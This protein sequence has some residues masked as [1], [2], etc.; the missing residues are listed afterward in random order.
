MPRPTYVERATA[1]VSNILGKA[2]TTKQ[3]KKAVDS[4]W[5]VN[6]LGQ[7][8]PPDEATWTQ[9]EVRA[10]FYVETMRTFNG[11]QIE[12]HGEQLAEEQYAADIAQAQEAYTS[13]FAGET[14]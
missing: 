9:P 3:V 7:P 14:P 4:V 8:F 11:R 13:D 2:A 12:M 5:A 1:I 10:Q 6:L